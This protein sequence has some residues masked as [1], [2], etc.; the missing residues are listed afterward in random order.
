MGGFL[1]LVQHLGKL[2]KKPNAPGLY[3]RPTLLEPYSALELFGNLSEIQILIN[4]VSSG[5]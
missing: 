1:V 5:V 4:E 3:S 2:K